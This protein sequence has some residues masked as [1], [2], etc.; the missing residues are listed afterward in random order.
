MNI[1][2]LD[3]LYISFDYILFFRVKPSALQN[4]V[5]LL[6]GG[7]GGVK[8]CPN[9][10]RVASHMITQVM[11]LWVT[12]W[13]K[14]Q[15]AVIN[16]PCSLIQSWKLQ[17]IWTKDWSLIN[18]ILLVSPTSQASLEPHRGSFVI[19]APHWWMLEGY[20]NWVERE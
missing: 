16:I 5:H 8:T 15:L 6:L 3:T 18:Q 12:V 17:S 19:S 20:L 11:T 13:I 14:Y 9:L 1:L 4:G 10:K 7:R 2:S